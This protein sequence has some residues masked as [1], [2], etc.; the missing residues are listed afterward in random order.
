MDK[1][2]ESRS[3]LPVLGTSLRT[4]ET[5][6]LLDEESVKT[7]LLEKHT[8]LDDESEG[9]R[10]ILDNTSKRGAGALNVSCKIWTKQTDTRLYSKLSTILPV[11]LKQTRDFIKQ[12]S[13]V[14]KWALLP[15]DTWKYTTIRDD[16][17]QGCSYHHIYTNPTWPMARPRECYLI[18]T[19][20]YNYG[21]GSFSV[22]SRSL[23]GMPLQE[24]RHVPLTINH[25]G[26]TVSPIFTH[27]S[28]ILPNVCKY[29]LIQEVAFEAPLLPS[30]MLYKMRLSGIP[31]R[32]PRLVRDV[33]TFY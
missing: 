1:K 4:H 33:E 30:S 9:W 28:N 13:N 2:R 25:I 26:V 20:H 5:I 22:I 29:T 16:N 18:S 15:Y 23:R 11:D 3:S 32:M 19:T 14:L 24:S 27:H 17:L 6:P 8:K 21:K 12:P 10:C 31:K 7:N